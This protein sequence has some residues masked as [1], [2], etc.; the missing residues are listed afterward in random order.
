MLMGYADIKIAAKLSQWRVAMGMLYDGVPSVGHGPTAQKS[1]RC[2]HLILA[3]NHTFRK[4]ADA[5]KRT[6]TIGRKGIGVENRTKTQVPRSRPNPLITRCRIIE[7]TS[8]SF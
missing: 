2:G 8:E 4:P 1:V 7:Q 3:E 5:L 6:T